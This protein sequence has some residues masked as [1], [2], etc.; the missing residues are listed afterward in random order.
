MMDGSATV[1]GASN[2]AIRTDID[3]SNWD[4]IDTPMHLQITSNYSCPLETEM[5]GFWVSM[6]E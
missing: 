6:Q 1:G 5:S 4:E 3:R 2:G